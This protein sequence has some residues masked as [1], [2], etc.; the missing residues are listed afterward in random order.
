MKR[1]YFTYPVADGL[2]EA[3][4]IFAIS[5]RDAGMELVVNNSQFQGTPD[6]P[7]FRDLKRAP[8][9]EFFRTNVKSSAIAG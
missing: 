1:A 2:L 7:S 6:D 5:A 3:V 4:T 9:F 8:S